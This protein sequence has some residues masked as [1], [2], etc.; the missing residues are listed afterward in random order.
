MVDNGHT[1]G[2]ESHQAQ[3]GPVEGVSLHHAPDGDPQETLFPAKVCRGA[4]LGA[5]DAGS[6]HGNT[7]GR[8]GGREGERARR[9]RG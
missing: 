9:E 1:H 7:W 2:V 4:T 5:P 8:K 3:H 6:G